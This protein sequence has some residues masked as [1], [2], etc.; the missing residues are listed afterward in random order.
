M[1]GADC[2]A[3]VGNVA[4]CTPA[5]LLAGQVVRPGRDHELRRQAESAMMSWRDAMSYFESRKLPS[6]VKFLAILCCSLV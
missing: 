3:V 5:M 6:A 1:N 2:K 4:P